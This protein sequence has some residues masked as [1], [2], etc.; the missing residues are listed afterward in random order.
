MKIDSVSYAVA[1]KIVKNFAMSVSRI[2]GNSTANGWLHVFDTKTVPT[3]GAGVVP[4]RSFPV[5]ATAPFDMMLADDQLQFENGCVMALSSVQGAYTALVSTMDLF[6]TGTS[7]YDDTDW[8]I[9]G[10]YNSAAVP[11]QVWADA[12]GPKKLVRVEV[13]D[14]AGAV[15]PFYA[16]IHASDTPATDKIVDS[17]LV[18]LEGTIDLFFGDGR[19]IG[20]T[21]EG[22]TYDGC[23]IAISSDQD[24]YVA[25]G[26]PCDYI[27]ATYR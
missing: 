3:S 13:S 12:D 25:F 19:A 14:L 11:L 21:E 15:G 24:T 10:D 16:Q 7:P 22:T 1:S 2:R 18:E 8:T 20:F 5:Y 6:V 27:R 4:L 26:S 9:A 23:T 17:F